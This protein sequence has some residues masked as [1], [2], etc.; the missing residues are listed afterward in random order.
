MSA[1]ASIAFPLAAI[2]VSLRARAA[3]K[4]SRKSVLA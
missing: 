3:V 2:A 4:K 1:P